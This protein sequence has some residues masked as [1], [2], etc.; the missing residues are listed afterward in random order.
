MPRPVMKTSWPTARSMRSSSPPPASFTTN[1]PGWLWN[2]ART[3]WLR[4]LW[5]FRTKA[6]PRLPA[7]RKSPARD[8]WLRIPVVSTGQDGILRISSRTARQATCTSTIFTNFNYAAKNVGWT[9]YR[10]SWTDDVLFHHGCHVLDYSLW[11]IDE[12]VRR[13]RGELSPL[14]AATGTSL[15]VSMLV[16]YTSETIAALSLS[17]NARSGVNNNIY[18]CDAGTLVVSGNQVALNGKVLFDSD[19]TLDDDVAGSE[20]RIHRI[21]PRRQTASMQRGPGLEALDLLQQI[22]DQ[23]ITMDNPDKYKRMWEN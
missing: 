12:P 2:P 23:S 8:S 4:S 7:L 11:T 15:D 22:Y 19:D 20:R 3:S 14:D 13:I 16:R 18:L 9:G 21:D 5:R 17:Y 10:R 6:P 1:R